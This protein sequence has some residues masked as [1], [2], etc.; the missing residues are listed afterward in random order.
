MTVRWKLVKVGC[1]L[2]VDRRLHLT[3]FIFLNR[4]LSYFPGKAF[5]ISQPSSVHLRATSSVQWREGRPLKI[6]KLLKF[7]EM[8][9]K[10]PLEWKCHWSI[11]QDQDHVLLSPTVMLL[12][13]DEGCRSDL[14]WW[15]K[16]KSLMTSQGLILIRMRKDI[17]V[18]IRFEYHQ[19]ECLL[20]NMFED[21]WG[22]YW[23]GRLTENDWVPSMHCTA[24]HL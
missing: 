24:L 2:H 13:F 3:H 11:S 18:D 16:N 1:L 19:K 10:S 21:I 20:E 23:H 4:G 14:I 7:P 6:Q 15:F 17:D 22:E 12:P 5:H 8:V 9:K